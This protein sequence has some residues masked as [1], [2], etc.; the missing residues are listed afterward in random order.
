L[1]SAYA[2]VQAQLEELMNSIAIANG[3]QLASR[4]PNFG[5]GSMVIWNRDRGWR[6]DELR[7]LFLWAGYLRS[8]GVSGSLG[9]S[10]VLPDRNV[11][12]DGYRTAWIARKSPDELTIR[13]TDERAPAAV[14][15]TLRSDIESS[16]AW[17]DHTYATPASALVRLRDD[18]RN[19]AGA[20]NRHY[21]AVVSYLEGLG[22]Q[23]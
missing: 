20:G 11:S 8:R 2:Q 1:A 7:L 18:D 13:E 12:V 15:E 3:F 21:R 19:G 5:K 10:I 22:T 4:N 9:T 14:I 6:K 23:A 17:L 16:I